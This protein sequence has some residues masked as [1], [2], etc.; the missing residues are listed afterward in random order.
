MG[1]KEDDFIACRLKENKKDPTVDEMQRKVNELMGIDDAT[2][3]KYN[4]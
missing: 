4:K 3:R 1:V 2:F